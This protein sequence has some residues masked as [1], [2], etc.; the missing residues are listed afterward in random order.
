MA[1]PIRDQD[2]FV[3]MKC[4]VLSNE[5]VDKIYAAVSRSNYEP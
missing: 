4:A 1:G 2:W 5:N 3:N